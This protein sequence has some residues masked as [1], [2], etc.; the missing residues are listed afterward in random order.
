[1][2]II[3]R[4]SAAL[5]CH[6]CP[7]PNFSSNTNHNINIS[8]VVWMGL[9]E[10][11]GMGTCLQTLNLKLESPK[12]LQ[13]SFFNQ[14]NIAHTGRTYMARINE[15][16][17]FVHLLPFLQ[18][19]PIKASIIA[20]QLTSIQLPSACPDSELSLLLPNAFLIACPSLWAALTYNKS[21]LQ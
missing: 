6:P 14:S 3:A 10:R 9:S 18:K 8:A 5:C 13:G 1:M 15:V 19:V 7:Q 16:V 4:L 12:S 20:S 2:V 21:F 17:M 11:P